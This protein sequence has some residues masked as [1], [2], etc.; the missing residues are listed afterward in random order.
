MRA[1]PFNREAGFSLLELII[2]MAIILIIAAMAFP[3]IQAATEGMKLRATITDIDGMLQQARIQAVRA[4][5]SYTM[6]TIAPA[7]TSGT[8]LYI[9]TPVAGNAAGNSTLDANEPSIELPTN[10]TISDGTGGPAT[11][12]PNATAASIK[13]NAV[14]LSFNERGLPCNNP[15]GC[16]NANISFLI[17]FQQTRPTGTSGWGA[18]TVTP[19][20]RIK[21]YTWTGGAAG[22]WQ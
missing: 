7:G 8:I 13:A 1:K 2:V 19:A 16:T 5:K 10:T 18:I 3:K 20:G 4:N 22:T 17:Y 21:A 9:D 15:P 12:P 14:T 11:L 6:R